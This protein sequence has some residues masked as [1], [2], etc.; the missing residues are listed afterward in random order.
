MLKGLLSVSLV[1]FAW[2]VASSVST[3]K[4]AGENMTQ[5]RQAAQIVMR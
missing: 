1:L 3:A 2:I 5:V 4:Q